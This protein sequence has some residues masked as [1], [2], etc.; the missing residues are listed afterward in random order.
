[1][2]ANDK[3]A[4]G[5]AS[6]WWRA[7]LLTAA[8]LCLAGFDSYK[9][10]VEQLLKDGKLRKQAEALIRGGGDTA[11]YANHYLIAKRCLIRA[12]VEPEVAEAMA[13]KTSDI[14]FDNVKNRGHYEAKNHCDRAME[15]THHKAFAQSLE[16]HR[17]RVSEAWNSL[18][19]GD[20]RNVKK[21]LP[22]ALHVQG[23]FFSHSNYVDL[24]PATREELMGCWTR[25]RGKLEG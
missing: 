14:D 22:R 11:L 25:Y 3:P 13:R 19:H 20:L 24:P 16:Y 21:I 8:A 6:R 23:D 18:S 12:G 7:G 1:M 4:S 15:V 10:P 17:Q 9:V 5:S 2:R